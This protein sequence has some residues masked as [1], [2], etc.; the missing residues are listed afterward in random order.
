MEDVGLGCIYRYLEASSGEWKLRWWAA[1]SQTRI[2]QRSHQKL[3]YREQSNMASVLCTPCPAAPSTTELRHLA[4][5]SDGVRLRSRQIPPAT[6]HAFS[7]ACGGRA[8]LLDGASASASASARCRRMCPPSA[9]PMANSSP[10][11]GHSC[12][13]G[14]AGCAG[15]G[16]GSSV[17]W[18]PRQ[19]SA[20][21]VCCWCWSSCLG[22]LW[23]ARWPPSAWN[24][25][26]CR[27][28]VLHSN[29]RPCAPRPSSTAGNGSAWPC[30]WPWRMRCCCCAC[31]RSTSRRAV[32]TAP[33]A[34]SSHAAL[35]LLPVVMAG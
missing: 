17:G 2:V 31:A 32:S 33:A 20:A 1:F 25:G 16:V 9:W 11:T 13:L 5:F 23:L 12:T 4:Q 8:T 30:P 18:R 34:C 22:R 10:Q 6:S 7:R 27:L 26:N 15:V 21:A 28:H 19:R 14:L 3:N 35:S 29:T 24:V